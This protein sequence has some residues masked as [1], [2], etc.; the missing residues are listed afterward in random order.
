M[1]KIL[2]ILL[3]LPVLLF[4]QTQDLRD[5]LTDSIPYTETIKLPLEPYVKVLSLDSNYMNYRYFY[6]DDFYYCPIAT[7]VDGCRANYTMF[8]ECLQWSKIYGIENVY[9]GVISNIMRYEE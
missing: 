1:K 4:G 5:R 3:F 9:V 6:Q 2:F 7:Y 8:N